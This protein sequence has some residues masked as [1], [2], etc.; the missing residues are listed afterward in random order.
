MTGLAQ[1]MLNC[2]RD[3][4][5][6]GAKKMLEALNVDSRMIPAPRDA[7]GCLITCPGAGVTQPEGPLS[8]LE[9]LYPLYWLKLA[10]GLMGRL[11]G[12]RPDATTVS[13][14]DRAP[15]VLS[16][17]SPQQSPSRTVSAA[18]ATGWGPMP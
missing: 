13:V 8:M 5:M 2:T 3:V 9:A 18:P 10:S 7:S 16:S 12:A 1:L 17:P 11:E 15:S 14:L 4:S 6:L